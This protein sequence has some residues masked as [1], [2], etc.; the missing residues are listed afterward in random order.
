METMVS[1]WCN[2][3]PHAPKSHATV[4]KELISLRLTLQSNQSKLSFQSM[5]LVCIAHFSTCIILSRFFKASAQPGPAHPSHKFTAQEPSPSVAAS[6]VEL[7][8]EHEELEPRRRDVTNCGVENTVQREQVAERKQPTDSQL[9]PDAGFPWAKRQKVNT[10]NS[11]A[12]PFPWAQAAQATSI[13]KSHHGAEAKQTE[14]QLTTHM[15]AE[16][17]IVSRHQHKVANAVEET[18]EQDDSSKETPAEAP[19][20]IDREVWKS[21]PT[22]IQ[23]ELRLESMAALGRNVRDTGLQLPQMKLGKKKQAGKPIANFFAKKS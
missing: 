21:L 15:K 6:A 7:R 4:S 13:H 12:F 14:P 17:P 22:E 1:L 23:R 5:S 9:R 20:H 2:T 8:T 18:S 3:Y 11:T 19:D 16:G 10:K